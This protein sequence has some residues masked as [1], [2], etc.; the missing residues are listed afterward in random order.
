MLNLKKK[1]KKNYFECIP[2]TLPNVYSRMFFLQRVRNSLTSMRN[3]G[4][5]AKAKNGDPKRK[6]NRT[7]IT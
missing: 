3:K 5:T 6:K 1:K 2:I 7:H 4:A